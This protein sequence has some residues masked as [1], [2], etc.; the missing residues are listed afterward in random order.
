MNK[1]FKLLAAIIALFSIT[2]AVSA[3]S[4]S[5]VF[6]G[7]GGGLPSSAQMVTE[8]TLSPDDVTL[9]STTRSGGTSAGKVVLIVVGGIVVTALV[10]VGCIWLYNGVSDCTSDL[11]SGCGNACGDACGDALS[12]AC[13]DSLSTSSCSSGVSNVFAKGIAAMPIFVP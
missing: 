6:S 8:D 12:S 13:S 4:T 1:G 7:F 3:E 9:M 10:V 2:F 5:Y 11:S